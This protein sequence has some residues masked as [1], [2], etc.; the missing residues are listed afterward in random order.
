MIIQESM[1]NP[2][3]M[4]PMAM[5][6]DGLP[7]D[8]YRGC[9]LLAAGPQRMQMT[10]TAPM[11]PQYIAWQPPTVPKKTR[12]MDNSMGGKGVLRGRGDEYQIRHWHEDDMGLPWDWSVVGRLLSRTRWRHEVVVA[13]GPMAP[14]CFPWAVEMPT[15][16][17]IHSEPGR[18]A[19]DDMDSSRASRTGWGSCAWLN[20][21]NPKLHAGKSPHT[22]TR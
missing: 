12:I 17:R 7:G 1:M 8:G 10:L 18:R 11:P 14:A 21:A 6:R 22:S 15:S 2:R 16:A 3:N 20:C 9:R 13:T 19:C 5:D 4:D